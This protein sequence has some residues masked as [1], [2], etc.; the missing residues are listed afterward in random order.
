[1]GRYLIYNDNNCGI[2]SVHLT[3]FSNQLQFQGAFGNQD[4]AMVP[5][6]LVTIIPQVARMLSV[7][8]A[9]IARIGSVTRML[10]VAAGSVL[11]CLRDCSKVSSTFPQGL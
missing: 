6:T 4:H 2:I 10:N 5:V 7:H 1:M 9:A 8:R 3:H 11:L